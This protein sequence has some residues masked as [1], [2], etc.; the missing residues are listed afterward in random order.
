MVG[1]DT[2]AGANGIA[3]ASGPLRGVRVVELAGIGPAPFCGMMLA[4]DA[5]WDAR[6]DAA[7][8]PALH[9]RLA[10][11]FAGKPRDEWCALLEGCDAC[12]SPVLELD[13][14]PAHPHNVAR[15]AFVTLDGVSQPAPAPCFSRTPG[16]ARTPRPRCGADGETLLRDCGFDDAAVAALRNAGAHG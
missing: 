13:E 15:Q 9:E 1:N 4:E 5:D 3:G 12:F 8:W 11:L 7:R 6:Y 16:G 10:T 14:A 2:D